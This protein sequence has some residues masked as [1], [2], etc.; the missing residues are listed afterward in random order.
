M[1]MDGE[2]VT[3][4]SPYAAIYPLGGPRHRW[5]VQAGPQVVH[6]TRPSPVPEWPGTSS[7]G[8]GAELSTGYE[9]RSRVLFRAFAMGTAG[10]GGVS[11]WLGVSLGVTL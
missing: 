1:V 4:F 10:Q 7:T 3:S 9:L 8:V 2:R 5:F 11:P 6:L